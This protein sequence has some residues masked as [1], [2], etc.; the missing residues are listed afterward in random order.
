MRLRT[1][2]DALAALALTALACVGLAGPAAATYGPESDSAVV[3][4]TT[5]APGGAVTVRGSD[6]L[7]GSVVTVTVRQGGEV[8]LTQK[9]RADSHGDVSVTLALTEVG[10]NTI[11]L[12]GRQADGT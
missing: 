12:T 8:Y 5:V 6:F 2:L 3:S 11:T 7:P 4:A 10:A 9:V 1:F